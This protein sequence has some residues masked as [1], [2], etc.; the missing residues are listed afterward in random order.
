M[1][2]FT[3]TMTTRPVSLLKAFVSVAAVA[4][5]AFTLG[6]VTAGP[7]E[8]LVVSY[9][10]EPQP[11]APPSIAGAWPSIAEPVVDDCPQRKWSK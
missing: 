11:L 3:L 8:K 10:P 4:V 1:W 7:N 2:R 6:R 9:I 5:T